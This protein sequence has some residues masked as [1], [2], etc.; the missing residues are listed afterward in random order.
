M[1]DLIDMSL[2]INN[3]DLKKESKIEF[4]FEG[5]KNG[6]FKTDKDARAAIFG[7]ENCTAYYSEL[8]GKL[9]DA[10]V[11]AAIMNSNQGSEANK[12]FAKAS[13]YYLAALHFYRA[14]SRIAGHELSKKA[15]NIARKYNFTQLHFLASNEIAHH[16]GAIEGDTREFNFFLKEAHTSF[17]NLQSEVMARLSYLEIAHKHA[18]SRSL[19]KN[20]LPIIDEKVKQIQS[21]PHANTFSFVIYYYNIQAF[22]HSILRDFEGMILLCDEA[23]LKLKAI[24]AKPYIGYFAFKVKKLMAF[25]SL[26][27][28][29]LAQKELDDC[30]RLAPKGSYNWALALVYKAIL[31]FHSNN[32]EQTAE[33]IGHARKLY[34]KLPENVRDQWLV[35]EAFLDFLK[36]KNVK[37]GKLLNQVDLFSRDKQGAN[38]P[39]IILEAISLLKSGKKGGLIDKAEAYKQYAHRNLRVETTIRS[40]LFMKMLLQIPAGRFKREVVERRVKQYQARLSSHDIEAIEVEMVPYEALWE[41]VLE[42]LD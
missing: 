42:L 40:N 15:C 18:N 2:N 21:I 32:L 31:G 39:V 8:K 19:K 37:M 17:E 41:K 6:E 1:K 5:I 34:N 3:L 30:L 13:K 28:Y 22:K 14:G 10:L 7:S 4:L 25:I 11:D 38:I 16:Y 12:A 29:G 35:I 27:E 20:L 36:G 9:R 23:L 26:S 24:K 33:A